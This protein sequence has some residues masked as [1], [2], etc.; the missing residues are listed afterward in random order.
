MDQDKGIA[1]PVLQISIQQRQL[2]GGDERQVTSW[3]RPDIT[4]NF[5]GLARQ[6]ALLPNTL[7]TTSAEETDKAQQVGRK[8][9]SIFII[10]AVEPHLVTSTR[11]RFLKAVNE[12]QFWGSE[13]DVN[14]SPHLPHH[15]P[16]PL[17]FTSYHS[18]I[19]DNGSHRPKPEPEPKHPVTRYR[20]WRYN[21]KRK[22]LSRRAG[23]RVRMSDAYSP[24]KR[25]KTK[26][27]YMKSKR[28]LR[29]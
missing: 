29:K 15:P 14:T 26:G 13:A 2:A 17:F 19:L 11:Q 12:T 7:S 18:S 6:T 25:R 27:P 3:P 23:G 21:S 4:T 1:I 5:H 20:L 16:L 9:E 8:Q 10:L 28:C 22:Y 24:S